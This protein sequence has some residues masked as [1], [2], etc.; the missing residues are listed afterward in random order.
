M[1][2]GYVATDG[3]SSRI[4]ISN[5]N[6]AKKTVVQAQNTGFITTQ[7]NNLMAGNYYDTATT[8]HT[9]FTITASSGTFTGG[10]VR[11][12]GYQKS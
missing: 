4:F 11:V 6:K 10:N 2:V 1:F 5:P 7:N 3:G 8:A 12:Y 9:A